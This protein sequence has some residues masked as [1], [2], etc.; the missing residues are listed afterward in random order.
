MKGSH[1]ESNRVVFNPR[2]AV[3]M[4]LGRA[5]RQ[6]ATD[7]R[8]VKARDTADTPGVSPWLENVAHKIQEE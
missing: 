5:L 4:D 6:G 8:F 3:M 7:Q 2:E 1:G